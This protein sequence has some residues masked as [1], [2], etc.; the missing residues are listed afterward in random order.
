MA[1]RV[2]I[3][4][5]RITGAEA[6][7]TLLYVIAMLGALKLVALSYPNARLSRAWLTLF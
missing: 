7:V 6:I 5:V 1:V 3:P 2:P 4:T